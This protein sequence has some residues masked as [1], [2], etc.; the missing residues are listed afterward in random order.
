V[1]DRDAAPGSA[2]VISRIDTL[3]P[4]IGRLYVHLIGESDGPGGVKLASGDTLSATALDTALDA[5]QSRQDCTVVLAV[6][7]PYSGS[8]LGTCHATGLQ[9][10]VVIA[11]GRAGD[12]AFFLP[13]PTLSSFT[14]KFLGACFQGNSL[15]DG[16][17]SG[18]GFLRLFL[19]SFL[20]LRI[21]PQ[22][23]DNGDGV[24]NVLDGALARTLCVGRRYAF[25][26]D[27]ASGLP[28]ILDVTTT[29]TA[30]PGTGVSYTAQ[31]IDG[32]VPDRVFALLVPPDSGNSGEVVATLPEIE[33]TRT[34]PDSSTWSAT[35]TAPATPGL[36]SLTLF[37]SY[38][39]FPDNK[40]SE[41]A[42]TGLQVQGGTGVRSWIQY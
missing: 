7:A 27:E 30:S 20:G 9:K 25:A 14:Q 42:F 39:D 37:A 21:E 31:L 33:F 34:A 26:G 17:L 28:F 10:R 1:P 6:D 23:D 40:L 36:Y 4:T 13:Q 35:F 24:Y 41:P 19:N 8:F 22:L 5:L 32:V 38:P 18:R 11:S 16:F 15:F 3:P 29:Q 2:G 12:G